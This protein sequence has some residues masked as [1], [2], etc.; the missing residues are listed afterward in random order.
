M[1]IEIIDSK[2]EKHKSSGK[3]SISSVGCCW[4]KK[5]LELK[6]LHKEEFDT[7]TLR[8]FEIGDMFHQ[9][10][11]RDL[12]SKAPQHGYQLTA[13]EVN[14]PEHQFLSGRADL[15]LS[16][17]ESGERCIVDVKSCSDWTFKKVCEGSCPLNYRNQ[18]QLYMHLFGIPKGYL[19]FVN[20][21]KSTVEEFEV[22]YDK[23]HCEKLIQEIADFFE[24]YVKPCVEPERCD[25]ITSPFGCSVCDDKETQKIL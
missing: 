20:K 23:D 14:I 15:I 3:F 6:G 7:K 4:K 22:V 16:H 25:K 9:M 11:C 1:L 19:L 21:A 18:V 24:D 5:Y 8:T 13:A 17:C 12:T 10:V 2:F